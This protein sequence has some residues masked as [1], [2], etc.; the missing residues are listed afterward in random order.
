MI[1]DAKLCDS[2]KKFPRKHLQ[3]KSSPKPNC[4]LRCRKEF[5]E[6]IILDEF[7]IRIIDKNNFV[8]LTLES[9]TRRASKGGGKGEASTL[10]NLEKKN[11]PS[12]IKTLLLFSLKFA[13]ND[14]I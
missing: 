8:Y 10:R 3:K 13:E 7:L 14:F 9:K 11:F 12:F 1:F 6:I 4:N 5:M 2:W